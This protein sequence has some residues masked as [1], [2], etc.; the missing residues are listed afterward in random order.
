MY[1]WLYYKISKV[2]ICLLVAGKNVAENVKGKNGNEFLN[3]NTNVWVFA[4]TKGK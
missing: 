1:F 2:L 3:N 4:L